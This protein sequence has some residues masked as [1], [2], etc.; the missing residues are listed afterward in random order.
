MIPFY[1]FFHFFKWHQSLGHFT[2]LPLLH[3]VLPPKGFK[4]GCI[5][6]KGMFGEVMGHSSGFWDLLYVFWLNVIFFFPFFLPILKVTNA[7]WF[8]LIHPSFTF[9]GGFLDQ[10]F[11]MLKG[12]P[13]YWLIFL[14]MFK[15]WISF[16]S[17]QQKVS[18]Y[19]IY[20]FTR[21]LMNSLI[22]LNGT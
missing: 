5:L 9:L 7:N 19:I 8:V 18:L 12:S 11:K 21:F 1:W 2:W 10:F 20:D 13:I 17:L 22:I 6:Y 14:P 15:R 16:I 4:Q 3:H